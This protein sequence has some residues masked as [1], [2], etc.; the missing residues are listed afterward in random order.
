M[1]NKIVPVA[2]L[3]NPGTYTATLS[4]KQAMTMAF[5]AA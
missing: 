5:R 2:N 1:S 4:S 3:E